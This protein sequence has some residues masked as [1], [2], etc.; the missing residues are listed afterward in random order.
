M[1]KNFCL[2]AFLLAIAACMSVR[3]EDL[4]S[5]VGQPVELLDTHPL[6]MTVPL[7]TRYSNDGV[8]VRNYR[9]GRTFSNCSGNTNFNVNSGSGYANSYAT[10]YENDVVCN[11]IFYIKNGKILRYAPTG[12]CYTDESVRPQKMY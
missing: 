7:E 1:Y 8:E 5:W 6:F 11:N 2:M 10:C 3:E 9:N 12:Q 4:E